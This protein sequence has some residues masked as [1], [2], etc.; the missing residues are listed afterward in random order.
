MPMHSPAHPE[1]VLKDV[2]ERIASRRPSLRRISASAGPT[3]PHFERPRWCDAG[4]VDSPCPGIRATGAGYPFR[5]Q[6]VFDV[7]Q[8]AK[9]KLKAVS[10]VLGRFAA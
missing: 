7:S 2:L 1:E 9:K 3:F 8:V 6:A 5:M 10:P 4:D